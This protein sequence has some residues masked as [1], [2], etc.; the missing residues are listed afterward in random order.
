MERIKPVF[1][2]SSGGLHP[3]LIQP[4]IEILGRDVVIQMGGG[5]HGHPEGSRAGAK[6]ARDALLGLLQGKSYEEIA[7]ESKELREALKKWGYVDSSF[8]KEFWE[9][10]EFFKKREQDLWK[11]FGMYY[12]KFANELVVQAQKRHTKRI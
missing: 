11:S 12:Q 6:A 9:I 4:I 2:V 5:I 3:G 7:R 10:Y 1:P 8:V